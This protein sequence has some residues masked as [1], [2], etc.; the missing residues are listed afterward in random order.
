MITLISNPLKGVPKPALYV[1]GAVAVGILGYAY[2][3]KRSGASATPASTATPLDP[4]IDPAT[5]IPYADEFGG[6][7]GSTGY[8]GLGIYDPS[9]GATF[10]TGYGTGTVTQVSSN[11]AWAQAAEAYLSQVAG[12]DPNTV[13]IALGRGLTGQYLTP[14]Q[15]NIW[16]AATGFEGYPPQPVPPLVTTPPAG[17]GGGGGSATGAGPVTG[18]H[19]VKT[20][21]NSVTVGWHPLTGAKGYIVDV[22]G[23]PHGTYTTSTTINV[24]GMKNNTAHTITVTPIKSDGS[25]GHSAHVNA[26]TKK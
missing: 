2:Y 17:Q 10:G 15:L 23:G 25:R 5:G 3:K 1:S 13:A 8:S 26:H 4:N 7:T 18:L 11:A 20:F 21:R 22:S 19:V 14:D 24:G 6:G 16:N 9:T 12:Y